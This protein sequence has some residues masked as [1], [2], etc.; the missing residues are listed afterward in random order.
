MANHSTTF[1]YPILLAA[2]A[3]VINRPSP[4]LPWALPR[5]S[6][7]STPPVDSTKPAFVSR[8]IS[9]LRGQNDQDISIWMY[10]LHSM[11]YYWSFMT[12]WLQICSLI[13][14]FCG[15]QHDADDW[16]KIITTLE[17]CIKNALLMRAQQFITCTVHTWNAFG[18]KRGKVCHVKICTVTIIDYISLFYVY[19]CLL[20][21]YSIILTRW[22]FQPIWKILVKMEIFPK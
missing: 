10:F 12:T 13:A 21:V 19:Y 4:S 2:A 7:S 14:W 17:S 11:T 6:H 16:C 9:G 8:K 3:G 22:W 15:Q 1:H 20:C 18:C 5:I